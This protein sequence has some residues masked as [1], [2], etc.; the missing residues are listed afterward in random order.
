MIK[1]GGRRYLKSGLTALLR[2]TEARNERAGPPSSIL[3]QEL[4][5]IS[6]RLLRDYHVN[7]PK[8]H[9]ERSLKVLSRKFQI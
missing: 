7:F 2:N 6:I 3:V 5:L 8:T 9:G 1:L 4:F